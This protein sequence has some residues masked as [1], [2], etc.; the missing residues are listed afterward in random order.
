MKVRPRTSAAKA[1]ARAPATRIVEPPDT[2][3]RQFVGK[4]R[5]ASYIHDYQRTFRLHIQPRWGGRRLGTLKRGE[6][7]DVIDE[8]SDSRVKV[9]GNRALALVRGL[10]NFAIKRAVP[11]VEV[12]PATLVDKPGEEI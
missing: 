1:K 11:G 6:V 10:F 12:N 3:E 9:I 5:A 4:G 8:I 7:I 2:I